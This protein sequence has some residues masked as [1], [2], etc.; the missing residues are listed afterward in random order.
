MPI[1]AAALA[2]P[3]L[4]AGLPAPVAEVSPA[5]RATPLA[6]RQCSERLGP[7]ATQRRAWEVLHAARAEAARRGPG[8]AV[9]NGV[10]PCQLDHLTRGYCLHVYFPC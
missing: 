6:A 1:L 5:A 10:T 8:Y 4:A 9:S 7:F 2:L 3:L